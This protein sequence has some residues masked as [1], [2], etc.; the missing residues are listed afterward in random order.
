MFTLFILESGFVSGR[1]L[2]CLSDGGDTI[3]KSCWIPLISK[4]L[5]FCA[6]LKLGLEIP[7][8]Y[9]LGFFYSMI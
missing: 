2:Y 5:P 1:G 9:I 6:S 3:I 4:T 8:G 7:S